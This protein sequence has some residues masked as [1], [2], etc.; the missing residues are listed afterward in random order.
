MMTS[1]RTRRRRTA[2]TTA[3]LIL[4]T[5]A[6]VAACGSSNKAAS[7][8][9]QTPDDTVVV[10][11]PTSTP[12]T[13]TP[14]ATVAAPE[15]AGVTGTVASLLAVAADHRVRMANGFDTPNVFSSVAILDTYG[16]ATEAGVLDATAGTVPVPD[17]VR[18]AIEKALGPITVHWVTAATDVAAEPT[19]TWDER[20]LPAL[21]TLAEPV[22]NG[23]IA[24]VVSDLRCGPGCVIGGGQAFA[25]GADDSWATV[26]PVGPQWQS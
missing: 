12:E 22:I 18:Q 3:S 19:A 4:L 15:S 26:G 16:V 1:T 8:A 13:S 10:T 24:T 25:M 9:A 14:I 20:P 5:A 17:D 6:L 21:L 11:N 2:V 7:T 23:K